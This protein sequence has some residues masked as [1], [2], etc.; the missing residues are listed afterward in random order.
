MDTV[1]AV[2]KLAGTVVGKTLG[3][4]SQTAGAIRQTAPGVGQAYNMGRAGAQKTI[5]K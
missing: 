5:A 2:G 3:G 1:G 4:V